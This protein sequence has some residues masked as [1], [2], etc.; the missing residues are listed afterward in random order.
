VSAL[1]GVTIDVYDN[2][3]DQ[4]V[5]D[6]SVR[7]YPPDC[8]SLRTTNIHATDKCLLEFLKHLTRQCWKID[9]NGTT[10]KQ[11]CY[12]QTRWNPH[13][14]R[15]GPLLDRRL[16]LWRLQGCLSNSSPYRTIIATR[17]YWLQVL[18]DTKEA[19]SRAHCTWTTCPPDC[20]WEAN[21]VWT[22]ETIPHGRIEARLYPRSQR[23]GRSVSRL[24]SRR[25]YH[26]PANMQDPAQRGCLSTTPNILHEVTA[27]AVYLEH[28]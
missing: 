20:T 19:A 7:L 5:I 8:S 3:R 23:P 10:R 21:L 16:G 22:S 24:V 18:L 14:Y 12:S 25:R 4:T 9:A 28:V 15:P 27:T 2:A 1:R 11:G 17:Q 26:G 13:R 6:S